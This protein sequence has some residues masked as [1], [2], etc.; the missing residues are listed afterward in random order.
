MFDRRTSGL[1]LASPQIERK[2]PREFLG[3]ATIVMRSKEA[4]SKGASL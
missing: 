1:G 3:K 4:F 2:Y